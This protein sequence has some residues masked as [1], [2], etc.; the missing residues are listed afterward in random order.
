MWYVI[1]FRD[2]L[3]LRRNR[4]FRSHRSICSRLQIAAMAYNFGYEF[5]RAWIRNY[6]L[7]FLVTVYT[8][9]QFYIT[10]VPSRLSCVFHVNCVN[11]QSVRSVV[12]AVPIPIQN[13]FNTTV[14][15]PSFRNGLIGLMVGNIIAVCG[16]EYFVVNGT[17]RYFGRKRRRAAFEAVNSG[18]ALDDQ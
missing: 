2:S 9:I 14:M 15:P 5:R 13:P 12:E 6:A 7:V 16:Y 1:F 11:E 3:M 10:L 4:A 18:K 17:R 8:V